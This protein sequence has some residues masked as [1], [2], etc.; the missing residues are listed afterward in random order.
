MILRGTMSAP[1]LD[2][3]AR[4]APLAGFR[5]YS[6]SRLERLVL[7]DGTVL[8]AKHISP[9]DWIARAAADP[10][11]AATLWTGGL[12]DRLPAT[13]DTAMV[14]AERDGD[15]WVLLMRDVSDHLV[16]S[17]G[18]L[19]RDQARR[20]LAATWQ[21]HAEFWGEPIDGLCRLRD[22]LAFHSPSVA[23][24]ERKRPN[25]VPDVYG[26]GYFDAV[27]RGWELFADDAPPDVG[28]AVLSLL[29]DPGP[30]VD[31]LAGAEVALNHGDLKYAN[32]GLTPDRVILLDWGTF[33]GM[34]PPAVDFAWF[35][36]QNAVHI[37]ASREQLVEDFVA[38]GGERHDQHALD[39]AFIGALAQ[40]GWRRALG[41]VH[42]TDAAE[43]HRDRAELDWWYR[44]ART[45]LDL[46]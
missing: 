28:T 37:D 18:V 32:L 33:T 9:D 40:L 41:A 46:W 45:T 22:R 21:L 23:A 4:R 29:D 11:R 25:A 36:L 16:S 2:R 6:G 24:R 10:G 38:L 19:R 7:D 43:R 14:A 34:A 35:L 39:H 20:L 31:A 17:T 15:G 44:R 12:L 13:I 5:S 8:V 42:G 26:L 1:I 30:L 3:V 27:L